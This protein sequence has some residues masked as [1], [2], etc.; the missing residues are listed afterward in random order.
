MNASIG[1]N[2]AGTSAAKNETPRDDVPSATGRL[3]AQTFKCL[4]A[5]AVAAALVL[6]V[7]WQVHGAVSHADSEMTAD[8]VRTEYLPAAYGFLPVDYDTGV[9]LQGR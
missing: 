3:L 4:I 2:K 7:S 6:C 5:P 8:D 1:C 9:Q